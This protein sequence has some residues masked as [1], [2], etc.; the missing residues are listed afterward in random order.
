MKEKS[1]IENLKDKNVSEVSEDLFEPC[2]YTPAFPSLIPYRH[3]DD[4]AGR[5]KAKARKEAENSAGREEGR[6]IIREF[7]AREAAFEKKMEELEEERLLFYK[8]A[9]RND[10]CPCGSGLKYKKCCELRMKEELR[11]IIL[12]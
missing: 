7:L 12:Q 6:R 8:D 2:R 5:K 9:G 1:M 4:I 3:P 11:N 10:P